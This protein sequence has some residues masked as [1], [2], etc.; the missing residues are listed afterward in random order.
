MSQSAEDAKLKENLELLVQRLTEPSNTVEIRKAALES[1]KTEIR[2]AT[3]SMTSI[4]KPLKFLRPHYDH[5]KKFYESKE[6]FPIKVDLAD[7]LSVLAMTMAADGTRE[8]LHFKLVGHPQE[9]A[10]WGHEYVRYVSVL[11]SNS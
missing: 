10:S 2:T 1:L 9:L 8:S 4:P 7:M 11:P 6:A 5:L 3:S